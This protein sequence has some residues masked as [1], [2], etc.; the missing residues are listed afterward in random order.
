MNKLPLLAFILL[1]SCTSLN[2][3]ESTRESNIKPNEYTYSDTNSKIRYNI[4]NDNKN[5]HI[6]LSTTDFTTINQ[7][8]RT[9]L[10]INFNLQ[11]KKKESIYFQYPLAPSKRFPEGG[12]PQ[13]GRD[14]AKAGQNMPQK[15]DG[16]GAKFDL[17][18]LTAQISDEALFSKNGEIE[19]LHILSAKSDIKVFIKVINKAELIYDFFI[20]INRISKDGISSLSKLSVGIISGKGD[21]S[22]KGGPEGMSKGKRGE[23]PGGGMEGGGPGGMGGG[24]MEGGMG[25]GPGGMGGGPGGR[26]G[27]PGDMNG[28]NRSST[29]QSINIWFKLDLLK[30]E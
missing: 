14:M 27:G 26:S 24:G 30:V 4:A 8:I 2:N 29:N 5:I 18:K 21:A 17:N 22:S 7:I 10:K 9:G 28:T 16:P 20:P 6:K 3:V 25:G 12:T 23:M 1:C 19:Q 11:G 15:G 13:A